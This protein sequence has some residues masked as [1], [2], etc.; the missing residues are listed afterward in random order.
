[1]GQTIT[2]TAEDG[3]ELSAYRADPDGAPR[4]GI[5]V[6]QEIFGVNGHIRGVCDRF[7]GEGYVA[8]APAVFDRVERGVELEYDSDG[9]ARGREIMGG[10]GLDGPLLD[11]AAAAAAIKDAGKVG[12]VG[13]CW[14][15]TVAWLAATRLKLPSVGYYGG[16]IV[17][18]AGE[19]LEVPVML[20][21]GKQDQMIPAE[22]V[23]KIREAAPKVPVFEYDEAGHGFNCEKRA[24]YHEESAKFAL[25]R[26]L[27]FLAE[28]VG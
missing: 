19:E 7:A 1:M 27:E 18:F 11:I 21:F 2:L 26:T 24:S 10:I 20:H 5:V 22:D 14:G 8:I 13:Y 28:N 15:G 23:A 12:S 16:R 17:D 25:T 6:I 4:G 9:M 3:H